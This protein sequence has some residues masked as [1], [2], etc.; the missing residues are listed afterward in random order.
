MVR[1][2]QTAQR[3]HLHHHLLVRAP[4]R[5]F[6]PRDEPSRSAWHIRTISAS[7]PSAETIPL[8]ETS[9]LIRIPVALIACST[10]KPTHPHP[11][12]HLSPTPTPTPKPTRASS[13][14]STSPSSPNGVLSRSPTAAAAGTVR[15]AGPAT[16]R[17]WTHPSMP[18]SKGRTIVRN[19]RDF[20]AFVDRSS[21]G[22]VA[23]A[24]GARDANRLRLA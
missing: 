24:G 11:H 22:A 2:A 23:A 1:H 21:A 3:C 18:V 12:L 15:P 19:R 13:L 17:A 5:E 4:A 14:P 20:C 9:V 16:E 10:S 6:Q 7:Y 8:E